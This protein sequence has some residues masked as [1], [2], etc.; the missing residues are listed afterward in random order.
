MNEKT[1]R[2][3]YPLPRIDDALDSLGGSKFSNL[4]LASGYCQ[5][6]KAK[7]D[8]DK[9]TTFERLME[10]I[11]GDLRWHKCSG[12]SNLV[13]ENL[14]QVFDRLIEAKLRLKLKK[15][16]LSR[17]KVEYLGHMVTDNGI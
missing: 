6:A 5:I 15:C 17:N 12:I 8:V 16:F 3:S 13:F 11:L 1:K 14:K 7:E 2:D 9:M 4:D 10:S